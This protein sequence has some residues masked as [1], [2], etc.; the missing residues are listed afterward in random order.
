M[1]FNRIK[2]MVVQ[3]VWLVAQN[4]ALADAPTI[5]TQQV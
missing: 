2:M 4:F 1:R 3:A 5:I